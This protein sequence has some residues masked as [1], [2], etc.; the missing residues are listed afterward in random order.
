[1]RPIGAGV[2]GAFLRWLLTAVL[3][4]AAG[5]SGAAEK[6]VALVIGIGAYQD[7]TLPPLPHAR[8]DAEAIAAKLAGLGFDVTPAYDLT[9]TQFETALAAFVGKG[10]GA[11]LALV[12][13]AGHGLQIAGRNYLVPSDADFSTSET[14][15]DS[16]VRL[17]EVFDRAGETA[18][19]R[20]ILVDACRDLPGEPGEAGADLRPGLA[21][22]GGAKNTLYAFAAA[23]GETADDG[24][25]EHGPF[26]AA[27]L[28][29]LAAPL[30]LRAVM[31][32]VRQDVYD[33]SRAA[34]LPFTEDGLPDVVFLGDNAA[35]TLSERDGLLLA[36][37]RLDEDT[38][39]QVERVAAQAGVP[40]APL[41]GALL[42][43]GAADENA[44]AREAR[45]SSAAKNFSDTQKELQLLRS[46]D[47]EVG[48][49][50]KQAEE[51][52]AL[53]ALDAARQALTEA[54]DLDDAAELEARLKEKNL[55]K[56]ESLA[57]RAGVARVGLR[58]LD[59]AADFAEAAR[60]ARRW[61][62]QAL[63]GRY[64]GE[65]AQA[66]Y[67]QGFEFGDNAALAEAI[68]LYR[69]AVAEHPR[70]ENPVEWS[71]AQNDLGRALW[72]L[73]EREGGTARLEEA[74]AARRAALEERS[75][76]SDP[77]AWGLTQNGL[78]LALWSLG[79]RESGTT[80]L[81]EAIAAFRA[82]LREMPR[83]RFPLE[84]AMA[85][86]N[87]GNA[88]AALG[89]RGGTTWFEQAVEAFREALKERT[90]ERIPLQW[91][92]TQNNLGS[93]LAEIGEREN[94][95]ARLREAVAAFSAALE[96]RTRKRV[97]LDW[98]TTENNL[99]NALHSL[100][101]HADDIG[102]LKE[103]VVAHRM[104]LEERTRERAPLDWAASQYTLGNAL[105][106]LARRERSV[107]RLN[108]AA[109]AYRA[110]LTEFTR[111]RVPLVWA[112][113]QQS[114][115][116]VSRALGEAEGG[117]ARFVEAVAAYGAA[118][119][120]RTRERAPFDWA[121]S[122]G[123]QG[124]VMMRLAEQ[125]RDTDMAESAIR[126]IEDAFNTMREGGNS[127]DAV[128]FERQL[129]LARTRDKRF[130]GTLH[131]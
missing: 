34:Q 27:L 70:E 39:G 1:M 107:A 91:A 50:R 42:E 112:D 29:H 121:M 130:R 68:E 25:G 86:N 124:I 53:G 82:A 61:E 77:L 72:S 41:Y 26:A 71:Q 28:E 93:A 95:P 15:P 35:T 5:V 76:A 54:I 40:L 90:R 99:G 109:A 108:E 58:Y 47:P 104:A 13:F 17:D 19:A 113:V 98:A 83:A 88:L 94:D 87:L 4:C 120:V 128:Y 106:A 116:N 78:G 74:V 117:A 119:Q 22:V 89:S 85:Q 16:S 3:V 33:R 6:R 105:F 31:T 126:Q 45:L 20:I 92:Q 101:E 9:R 62:E 21:R 80:R 44:Q 110:A 100:G 57:A 66:L 73:G 84:W 67:Q 97:P 65:Q 10:R 125:R 56:A 7:F 103:S 118:L 75:P 2:L 63:A 115:G 8:T 51:Q 81:E 127:S 129:K 102:K 43:T 46:S 60:L 111:D 14:L 36:M 49:L 12:Y 55:S 52:L 69:D 64:A 131:P 23:P 11:T 59:A 38:R 96:E 24:A 30:E 32:L 79:E 48:A 114:L 18:P 122:W 37:A 123:N